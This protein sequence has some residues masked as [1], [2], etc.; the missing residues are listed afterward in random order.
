VQHIAFF[1]IDFEWGKACNLHRRQRPLAKGYS[2][3]PGDM[4]VTGEVRV[5]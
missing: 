2:L 3:F 5:A 4:D 1:V